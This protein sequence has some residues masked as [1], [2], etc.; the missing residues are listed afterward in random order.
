MPDFPMNDRRQ[1]DLR[2]RRP[3]GHPVIH[4]ELPRQIQD[5]ARRKSIGLDHLPPITLRIDTPP[6]RIPQTASPSS[7]HSQAIVTT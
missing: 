6:I 4:A 1:N 2:T 3:E 7:S 5:L